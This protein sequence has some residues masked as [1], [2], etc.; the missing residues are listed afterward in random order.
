MYVYIPTFTNPVHLL[1]R[2]A[3]TRSALAFEK[4]ALSEA[5]AAAVEKAQAQAAGEA[6]QARAQHAEEAV[7][8]PMSNLTTAPCTAEAETT[9]HCDA[10]TF[11]GGN[12][13]PRG[14]NPTAE[15]ETTAHCDADTFQGVDPNPRG[16]NP[17]AEAETTAPCDADAFQGVDPNPR[18][19]P[20]DADTPQEA[21]N[22]PNATQEERILHPS[23]Y[24]AVH[25]GADAYGTAAGAE[26][27]GL[28]FE[29][30][31]L[32]ED[33]MAAAV[34]AQV[35]AVEAVVFELGAAEETAVSSLG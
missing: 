14:V 11:Q 4:R 20:C 19:N 16:I 9:A 23:N 6:Q 3:L 10:D 15:A 22:A 25:C 29:R 5:A 35:A 2:R 33:A 1:A 30:R 27:E 17:T 34:E 24:G 31:A 8:V 32:S 21:Q 7:C 26:A 18:V 12:P 28:V 13:N